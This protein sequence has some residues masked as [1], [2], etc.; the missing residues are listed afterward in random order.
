MATASGLKPQLLRSVERGAG[1]AG[2]RQSSLAGKDPVA[3]PARAEPAGAISLAG[4][5]AASSE[6]RLDTGDS[7]E[8][9]VHIAL[10]SEPVLKAIPMND[11]FDPRRLRM[12]DVKALGE[13]IYDNR[14]AGEAEVVVVIP[15]Y[16]YAHTITEALESVVK[17]DLAALAVI[18]VDDS[19]TDDG[20]QQAVDFLER[21]PARFS[22]AQVVRHYCNQGLAMARNSGIVHSTEPL[23]F[24]LDA[25][26][27]L[28]RP[29]LSRL[30]DALH[31][32]GADFAYSQLRLFDDED[33]IGNAD[34]WAPQR[35]RA[36]NYID[37]MA[38]IRREALLAARG[39][40]A[41]AVE[42]GWEDYDLWCRFAELGFEGV[43]L[44]ELL[45]EYRVHGTSMLRNHTNNNYT[46][47]KVEMRLR[48]PKLFQDPPS[49]RGEQ[50]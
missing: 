17:Q 10:K 32:S 48:H 21:H 43:F 39:Y 47:L 24:M 4:F 31:H 19:S 36:V 8:A 40:S 14:G 33:G 6:T 38:L 37:A 30:L 20:G 16:N 13:T 2:R 22:Q 1:G 25:D 34:I 12:F 15:L 9:A 11:R 28:R 35:L 46:A 50:V 3:F 5:E 41:S 18:V 26:N 45:C 42:Q 49:D 27:R 7:S 29:A 44:P 23:L